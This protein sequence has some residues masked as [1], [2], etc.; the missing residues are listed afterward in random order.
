MAD[1]AHEQQAAAV[2]HHVLATRAGVAAVVVQAARELLPALGEGLGQR[3]LQDA[4]PVAVG[5][6]LVVGVDHGHRVFQVQDGG[7]RRFQHQVGHA[8]GVGPADGVLGVDAD[9][10]VQAVVR[11]QHRAGRAHLAL[12]ADELRRVLQAHGLA[13]L[14]RHGQLVVDHA[15]GRAVQ[16]RALLQRH[17]A[18]EHV[19]RVFDDPGAAHRVVGAGARGATFFAERVGA[20]QRVVKAAPARVG[21]VQRV[22][23]VGDGHHQLRAGLQRQLGVDVLRRRLHLGRHRHQVADLLQEGAVA[24]H[25]ADGARVGLVPGVELGLQA[26]ALGQQRGVLR[27]QVAHDGVEAGPEGVSV[28]AGAGQHLLFDELVQVGGHLQAVDGDAV[29][30]GRS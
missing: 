25:C 10:H 13:V 2:Q 17:A 26:V 20:V 14:Q 5:L 15:V 21:G 1:V 30:H 27:R 23:C 7:Q 3:A 28:D 12:E 11:Q 9:V 19:A 8:R 6:H 22:A 16:V 18:V 4:Q 24:L 29:G